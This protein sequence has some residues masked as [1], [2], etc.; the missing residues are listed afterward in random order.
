[1]ANRWKER[2]QALQQERRF[3]RAAYSNL[4]QVSPKDDRAHAVLQQLMKS[5]QG[6]LYVRPLMLFPA[7]NLGEVLG[8]DE[9]EITEIVVDVMKAMGRPTPNRQM[10][11][12]R[13]ST[14]S[15]LHSAIVAL[16]N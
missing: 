16:L 11:L 10:L 7:D 14:V 8:L 12:P 4:F 6:Y 15:D 1:M 5:L 2:Q 9:D 3:D 13:I